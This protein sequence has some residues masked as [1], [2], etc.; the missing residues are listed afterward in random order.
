MYINEKELCE[1]IYCGVDRKIDCDWEVSHVAEISTTYSRRLEG[2]ISNSSVCLS[3][4]LSSSSLT[5]THT[6][7]MDNIPTQSKHH[8]CSSP[9]HTYIHTYVHTYIHTQIHTD[10]HIHTYIH[11]YIPKQSK[12]HHCWSLRSD[13]PTGD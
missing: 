2:V 1:A 9:L 5:N 6:L 10:T 7:N 8:P 13:S 12:L 11:T 4:F 3:P